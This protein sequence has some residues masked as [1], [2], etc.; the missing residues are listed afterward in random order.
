MHI[1]RAWFL[2]VGLHGIKPLLGSSR[3][4]NYHMD[5]ARGGAGRLV[6]HSRTDNADKGYC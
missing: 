1:L 3:R 5:A 2:R 6:E 4:R